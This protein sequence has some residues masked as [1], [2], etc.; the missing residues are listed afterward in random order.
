MEQR[1]LQLEESLVHAQQN[2]SSAL[3]QVQHAQQ[4]AQAQVQLARLNDASETERVTRFA[5]PDGYDYFEH[6]LV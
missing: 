1:V 6:W 2:S 5:I 4:A 3:Q